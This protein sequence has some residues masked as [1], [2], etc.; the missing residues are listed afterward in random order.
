MARTGRSARTAPPR[1]D[2]ALH[3]SL[4]RARPLGQLELDRLD[5]GP[6]RAAYGAT[7]VQEVEPRTALTDFHMGGHRD[8]DT[9]AWS[10]NPYTGCQH[11]CSY[12]FVPDTMKAQRE[13]WGRYVIVKRTLPTRLAHE[14]RRKPPGTTYLS[15][16]TDPYQPVEEEHRITRRCLEELARVDWPVDILTRSPLVLRDLD[17]LQRLSRL[18]VGLSVP[19]LDDRVRRAVEPHAPP[20]KARL[21]ALHALADAGLTT[22]ANYSPAYPFTGDATPARLAEAFRDAGVQ[23]ANASPWRRRRSILPV[24]AARLRGTPYEDL[25]PMIEDDRRQRRMRQTLQVAFDR[26]GVPLRTGFFNPPQPPAE[27]PPSGPPPTRTP[28]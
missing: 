25:L 24:V 5:D 22:Y 11:R 26:V 13:R 15:T 27:R 20:I 9:V 23:W 28:A 10:L 6:G 17:V 16:A 8:P 19:T 2:D 7:H 12:C 21:R 14:L 18:R 3:P 1:I 4:R